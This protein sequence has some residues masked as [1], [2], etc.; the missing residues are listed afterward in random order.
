MNVNGHNSLHMILIYNVLSLVQQILMN[1]LMLIHVMF[2]HQIAQIF[3]EVTCVF[4]EMALNK[5]ALIQIV[6]VS[7]VLTSLIR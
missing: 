1:V 4:V 2:P 3:K 7:H 6:M 5:I